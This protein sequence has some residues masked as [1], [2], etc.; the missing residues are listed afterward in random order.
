MDKPMK[1]G[2]NIHTD[3]GGCHKYVLNKFLGRRGF[4]IFFKGQIMIYL[5]HYRSALPDR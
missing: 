5:H 3:Y 4:H 2:I 1:V